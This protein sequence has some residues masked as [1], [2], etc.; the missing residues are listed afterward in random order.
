MKKIILFLL[1]TLSFSSFGQKLK[2]SILS[3][4]LDTYRHLTISLPPSY[5]RETKKVYPLLFL[6]DGDYLFD[7]FQGAISYGNYWDD[8]P[9]VILSLI[10]I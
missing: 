5:D 3:K 4:K 2:D 6:L 9:E 1:M 8:L 7:P 10:H